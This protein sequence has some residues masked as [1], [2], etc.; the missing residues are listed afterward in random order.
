M[1]EKIHH[2]FSDPDFSS[3][4]VIGFKA[5]GRFQ[6]TYI[7]RH[8]VPTERAAIRHCM[9]HK[10]ARICILLFIILTQHTGLLKC[11]KQSICSAQI[12]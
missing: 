9:Q 4:P 3:P 8:T 6:T 10:V 1:I 11:S 7:F 5:F 12:K 2:Q